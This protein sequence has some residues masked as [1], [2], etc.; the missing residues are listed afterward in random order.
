MKSIVQ[1]DSHPTKISCPV[2]YDH[3]VR[4]QQGGLG[5]I[6]NG[7]DST[8]HRNVAVKFILPEWED[9]LLARGRFLAE[10]EITGRLDHPGSPP[11]M[12]WLP[13]PMENPFMQ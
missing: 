1:I 9:D 4:H 5:L 7:H 13:L 10:A 6:C 3:L 12:L 8:L 2:E 11:S